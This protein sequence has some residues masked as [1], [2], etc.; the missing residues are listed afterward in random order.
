VFSRI[1]FS[2]AVCL[3]LAGESLM[4]HDPHDPIIT[5]AVSPNF[6]QD[7]TAFAATDYLSIKPGVYALLKSTNAGL[8]WSAVAGLPNVNQMNAV[9]FSPGYGTT[10]QTIYVAGL[11]GLYETT[12]QGT[13][14][15]LASKLPLQDVA[16]SA[17]FAT[18][19]TLFIVTIQMTVFKSTNRGQTFTQLTLPSTVT[20]LLNV[21][22]VS[23]N[24]DVDGTLLLGS[25]SNGIFES[26]NGGSSW[27]PVSSPQPFPS[28]TALTFSPGFSSDKTAFAGTASGVLISTNGGSS[29]AY[30]NGGLTDTNVNS[31]TLS[32]GYLQNSTLWVATAV[33][34]VFQST[35]L[36][37][38]WAGVALINRE[39]SPITT[40][41]YHNVAAGA[42]GT[43]TTLILA[44]Y[45]GLWTSPSSSISWQYID[46]MPTRLIR[47]LLISPNYVN[48]KT[49]FGNTYGGGN[50][51][52]TTGGASWIFENTGMQLPY[53][54]VA[55]IST[56]F[57]NDKTAFS[58]TGTV[59]QRTVNGG[60]TWQPMV[61]LGVITHA[62]GM[63]VSPAIA[64]DGT[65]L[66]GTDNDPGLSYPQ[67]VT[68]QGKQYPNQGLF[69]STNS[70]D[71]WI[72]T[73]L[74][75]PAVNSISISPGFG[76][77]DQ[78]AFATSPT[79]GLYESTDGGMTWTS[80]TLPGSS[81]K[82]GLV[83]VSP[84]FPTD[85]TVYVAPIT[86]G[87]LKSTNGGSTWTVLPRTSNLM[88][89][90]LQL[91]PNYVLDQTFFAA[92]IQAGVMKSTN[93]GT[94]LIPQST[95][96]DDF[97]LALAI[98]PNY[99]NDHTVFAA[100]YHSVYK[101][102]TGGSQWTDTVE[103]ARIEESRTVDST[104]SG[105]PPPTITYN[106]SWSITNSAS[107]STSAY[108]TTTTTQNTAV[109]NFTGTGIRW[110][111][112]TG[113][114]QG[115]ATILLDGA[116]QGTVTL[117]APTNQYQQTVWIKQGLPCEAHTFTISATP[118][119][120]QSVTLDAFDIWI[121]ACPSTASPNMMMM[122]QH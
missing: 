75:G 11:G 23:P 2:V 112:R 7:S 39:L 43:G 24:Y 120:G 70:G 87:L 121:N 100:A 15:T 89:L 3:F 48:D 88:I 63:A 32:P 36:G 14:W 55:A 26:T 52:S 28:V 20:S 65:V 21:I 42:T 30:S 50:L 108:M 122:H 98:S 37:A 90:D 105:Q 1:L 51:W 33:G 82:L 58:G 9:V 6:A 29:W 5:V 13:S 107:A 62:R 18:D 119:S 69:L 106:G 46:T 31:I 41:H 84:G 74:G 49:I 86:G 103:P 16:L 12:N 93:G 110:V 97:A 73:S 59:L 85:Q 118:Q 25:T 8:T 116:S 99:T 92:T 114:G 22:A 53:T 76:T 67:Y 78:T 79:N 57:A 68:Y 56:N 34:G 44:T 111:S 117:T 113:P 64:Q 10:D 4:A 95:F 61:A 72:P 83:A 91:S 35:N 60:A 38:S 45:E 54:D 81:L 104:T 66:I 109:L 47:H 71:N 101:S 40:S 96:P 94:T 17:N 19:N 77:S 102:T 27:V 115:S 80:I